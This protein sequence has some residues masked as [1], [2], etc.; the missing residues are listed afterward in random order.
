MKKV[1]LLTGAT[2]AIGSAIAE[3]IAS[4]DDYKLVILCRNER[5]AQGIIEKLKGKNKN[6]DLSYQLADLAEYSQ[7]KKL[8]AKWQGPLHVLIN[9]AAQTPH[10]RME[11]K[12]G[13]ELQFATN[14]MAYFWLTEEFTDL[15]KEN[16]PSRIVNVASYWAGDLDTNDLQFQS[17]S[18]D[19]NI[20]Y[21]QAKQANRMLTVAFAERLQP[22][23]IS[24]NACHPGDVNSALSRSLGFGGYQSPQEGAQ[25][26][27]WLATQMTNSAK[28]GKYF[29]NKEEQNC[30]FS[31]DRQA[32]ETL[33]EICKSRAV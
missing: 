16:T 15:L 14:I 12:E 33:Y 1:V 27:I 22:F 30:E 4:Q 29:S 9:N 23:G 18:Y 13:L 11:S 25:T 8:R 21:R 17:R 26:P 5:K 31:K 10:K 3:G 19:N 2:G 7:I 28:T 20:A 24:V 32:I 6:T